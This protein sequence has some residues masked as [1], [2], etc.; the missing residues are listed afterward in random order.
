[1]KFS[2][3]IP[4]YNYARYLGKTIQSVLDQQESAEAVMNAMVKA[5]RFI[6]PM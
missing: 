1:M 5:V 3:C 2:I 4:N 6:S